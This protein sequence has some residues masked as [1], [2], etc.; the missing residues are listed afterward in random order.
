[1][2]DLEDQPRHVKVLTSV[3]SVV[4]MLFFLTIAFGAHWG[5]D[6]VV[7]LTATIVATAVA[8]V[9]HARSLRT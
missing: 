3:A 2:S 8:L 4:W 1:M 7:L 9:A 6:S 5:W